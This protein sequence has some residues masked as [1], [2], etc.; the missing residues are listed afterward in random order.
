MPKYIKDIIRPGKYR[1]MGP[2]GKRYDIE[3]TADRIRRWKDTF[4]KYRA[5]G[6]Q[7]LAPIGH[8]NDAKPVRVDEAPPEAIHNQGYW[9]QLEIAADGTLY[10]VAELPVETVN[11]IREVSLFAPRLVEDG[12]GNK[13]EDAITHIALV[14]Q[15]IMNKQKRFIPADAAIALSMSADS[16]GGPQKPNDRGVLLTLDTVLGLLADLGIELPPDTTDMNF[17]DRLGTALMAIKSTKKMEEGG[18]DDEAPQGSKPAKPAAVVMSYPTF[19]AFAMSLLTGT[20]ATDHG[21]PYTDAELRILFE[22]QKP[23]PAELT[24]EQSAELAFANSA[25]RQTFRDR[26]AKC[27]ANGKVTKAIADKFLADQVEKAP[28]A[29]SAAGVP[30]SPVLEAVLSAWEAL[31][32]H[33]VLTAPVAMGPQ[34][35]VVQ[36]GKQPGEQLPTDELVKEADRVLAAAGLI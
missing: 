32:D 17:M 12:S 20:A 22:A 6:N 28:I 13:F 33:S 24:P 35:Q 16:P 11:K 5:A 7:V 14:T 27:V 15:P 25:K 34:Y 3:I 29:L 2:D 23:K 18:D 36:P 31:P 1:P 10:G 26:V 19:E 4:D 21:K 9:E 8:F 30:D